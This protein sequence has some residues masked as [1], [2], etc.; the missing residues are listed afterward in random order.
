MKNVE[1]QM[2]NLLFCFVILTGTMFGD[3]GA[4]LDPGGVSLDFSRLKPDEEANEKAAPDLIADGAFDKAEVMPNLWK[5]GTGRWGRDCWV[6]ISPAAGDSMALLKQIRPYL[7]V[8]PV[9]QTGNR[10]YRLSSG[11]ETLHIRDNKK[12]TLFFSNTLIQRVPLPAES[13]GK[14]YTL[15][16]RFRGKL[17]VGDNKNLCRVFLR[18]SD[19]AGYDGG[20]ILA[21]QAERDFKPRSAWDRCTIRFTVPSEAKSLEIRFVLYGPGQLDLDD[22]ALRENISHGALALDL[23]P[24]IKIDR[25]YRLGQN[26][27][28]VLTFDSI[29]PG[30]AP[31]KSPRFEI[32]VPD[33]FSISD[34]QLPLLERGKTPDGVKYIYSLDQWRF[35]KSY[36]V[37]NQVNL[38][39]RTNHV[40]AGTKLHATAYRTV[41][42]NIPGP[43]RRFHF[44][45]MPKITAPQPKRFVSGALMIRQHRL[46][47]QSSKNDFANFYADCGFNRM[48]NWFEY[49][50]QAGEIM[51]KRN[52]VRSAGLYFICN[53]YR[54]GGGPKPENALFRL[55]DGTPFTEP[56]GKTFAI[57]PGE[58]VERGPHFREVAKDLIERPIAGDDTVDVLMS[59]H[60][61]FYYAG[62][63]CFC[64][65]CRDQFADYLKRKNVSFDDQKLKKNWPASASGY[66]RDWVGFC[67]WQHG[68]AVVALEEAAREAGK[69][70]G[71]DSHYIPEINW[72]QLESSSQA[73]FKF[74]SVTEYMT[75]LEWLEPWGPYIFHNMGEKYIYTPGIH[76]ATF[77]AGKMVRDFLRQNISDPARIPKLLAFPHG[78]QGQGIYWV[79][80]PEA[81]AFE[82]LCFFLNRWEGSLLYMMNNMDYIYYAKMAEA[83][84]LIARYEDF[85]FDGTEVTADHAGNITPMI[86]EKE[87]RPWLNGEKINAFLCLSQEKF[88][89]VIGTG[90]ALRL[91]SFQLGTS[92]LAAVGNFWQRGECFFTLRLSGLTP[93]IHYIVHQPHENRN[94]GV[95]TGSELQRGIILHVG[96]LRWAFYLIEP[97]EKNTVYGTT[98]T[99]HFMKEEL[100]RRLPAVSSA[101]AEECRIA[102]KW[103]KTYAD[104][105]AAERSAT[106]GAAFEFGVL[107]NVSG[108]TV[109]VAPDGQGKNAALRVRT[110]QYQLKVN[111]AHG[112]VI[113]HWISDDGI[114]LDIPEKGF[115][116]GLDTILA[117]YANQFE[118]RSQMRLADVAALKDG[119]KIVLERKLSNRDNRNLSG[120]V[121]TKTIVFRE[122]GFEIT[123]SLHNSTSSPVVFSYRQ[124]NFAPFSGSENGQNGTAVIGKRSFTRDMRHKLLLIDDSAGAFLEKTLLLKSEKCSSCAIRFSAPWTSLKIDVEPLHGDLP[125]AILIWECGRNATAEYI[126]ALRKLSPGSVFRFGT[127]WRLKK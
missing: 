14:S 11:L 30:T 62:K 45:V 112:G 108:G 15:V 51:K 65:R 92:R 106:A 33:G 82:H 13:S 41:N 70:A 76:L 4:L 98:L 31:R 89:P 100:K 125:A 113:T 49:D 109:V 96:A 59:N 73:N 114:R 34:S 63:G 102:E 26:V 90:N 5:L 79:T 8:R 48:D 111:P 10:F 72:A 120:I 22:V 36:S 60:E 38:M 99:Q 66:S 78:I 122:D 21:H 87:F 85:L 32:V 35:A 46:P 44:A 119:V 75:E 9:T 71:K 69:K 43:W 6:H 84:A 93:D 118:I 61:P 19:H 117:P 124:H 97:I 68:R 77:A 58:M 17:G 80:E 20:K 110:P 67:S 18:F 29:D 104:T 94:F 54:F 88:A 40:P 28:N 7:E 127:V 91:K 16:F 3:T 55:A 52:I 107:P 23:L 56:G 116:I 115:G 12:E 74:Y 39:V 42:N 126:C 81:A 103:E 47:K 50:R 25:I 37:S 101:Y 27:P 57:C 2:K 105:L 1:F 121:F 53:A 83:N 24:Q 86:G 64:M 95:F 123:S